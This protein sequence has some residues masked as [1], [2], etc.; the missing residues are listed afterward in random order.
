M[1]EYLS[2][3]WLGHILAEA[4]LLACL[5]RARQFTKVPCFSWFVAFDLTRAIVLLPLWKPATFTAYG[6]AFLIT[7]PIDMILLACAGIEAFGRFVN[8]RPTVAAYVA[9]IIPVLIVGAAIPSHQLQSR[10]DP[11]WQEIL[12]NKMF[13]QRALL[14]SMPVSL[15]WGWGW[16]HGRWPDARTITLMVFCGFDLVT[17]FSLAI[18]PGWVKARPFDG[19]LFVLAGQTCCLLALDILFTGPTA[20]D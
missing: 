9:L 16:W 2:A 13:M 19:P 10:V 7:E 15:L 18:A 5:I 11:T 20:D 3:T 1:A 12:L 8:E 6:Y 4:L 17:Y 14:T